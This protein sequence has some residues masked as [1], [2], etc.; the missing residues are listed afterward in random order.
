MGGSDLS[1]GVSSPAAQG[2]RPAGSWK[3]V[4]GQDSN[5]RTQFTSR[6]PE[7]SAQLLSLQAPC[8]NIGLQRLNDWFHLLV[9]S[10]QCLQQP[11]LGQAKAW[12]SLRIPHLGWQR[13]THLG[14]HL[15]LPE[16][17]HRMLVGKWSPNPA[18]GTPDRVG[19]RAQPTAPQLLPL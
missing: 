18:P 9:C 7:L 17:Q 3:Q 15:L 16:V 10:P 5:P 11:A 2:N 6:S 8:N 4:Q 19:M 12:D 13:S 1:P 14:L